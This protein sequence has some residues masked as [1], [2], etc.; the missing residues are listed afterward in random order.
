[1]RD[2]NGTTQH[3]AV[4]QIGELKLVI[5]SVDKISKLA[6]PVATEFNVSVEFSYTPGYSGKLDGPMEDAEEPLAP[7][8]DIMAIRLVADTHFDSEEGYAST[9]RRNTD[10]LEAFTHVQLVQMVDRLL[11]RAA[12][13]GVE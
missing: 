13:G 6:E 7:Q 8:V 4:E 2:K 12:A 1:M 5:N 3:S 9:V 11:A 10:I